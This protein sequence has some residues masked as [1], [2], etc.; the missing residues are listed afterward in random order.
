MTSRPVVF[1]ARSAL[2]SALAEADAVIARSRKNWPV[3][4]G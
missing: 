1:L 4:G 3:S 2:L